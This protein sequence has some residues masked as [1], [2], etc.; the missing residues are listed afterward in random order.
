MIYQ[1]VNKST[2]MLSLATSH[3]AHKCNQLNY[4]ALPIS[5]SRSKSII[6]L[7][8]PKIKLF[9]QKNAK[10][11]CAGGSAPRP[12]CLRPLGALPLDSQNIPPI[13]NFWLR[14]CSQFNYT[15]KFISTVSAL[16]WCH[17]QQTVKTHA[18]YIQIMIEM[19]NKTQT[20][21]V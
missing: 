14:A 21:V 4:V 13:A 3:I 7:N 5:M 9:L 20:Y 15:N 11:S 10:F 18:I 8:S 17:F 19:K 1:H 16:F 6:F 12:P 2:S